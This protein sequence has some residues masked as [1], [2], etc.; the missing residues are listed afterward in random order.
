MAKSKNTFYDCDPYIPGIYPER[1]PRTD[2]FANPLNFFG[3]ELT[4]DFVGNDGQV[5]AAAGTKVV[6]IG[7]VTPFHNFSK[8]KFAVE[9]GL[10]A[11]GLGLS[12]IGDILADPTDTFATPEER[13]NLIQCMGET[14]PELVVGHTK[15]SVG[16]VAVK[17][18]GFA[19]ANNTDSIPPTHLE[20]IAATGEAPVTVYMPM[21]QFCEMAGPTEL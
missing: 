18:F 21:A 13:A 4:A 14:L 16:A 11:L 6:E 7:A 17:D 2:F 12:V 10:S 1:D 8:S 9:G 19:L 5:I 20:A 3:A 15:E